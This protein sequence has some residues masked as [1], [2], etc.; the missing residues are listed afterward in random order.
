[1]HK[2]IG[3]GLLVLGLLGA[4]GSAWAEDYDELDERLRAIEDRIGPEEDQ[5]PASSPGGMLGMVNDLQ[6]LQEEV[7]K[8]RGEVERLQYDAEQ[9]RIR[10]RDMFIDI[11]KR[12]SGLENSGQAGQG[13][14]AVI[15][16]PQATPPDITPPTLNSQRPVSSSG[17]P[18]ATTA[19]SQAA[20]RPSTPIA[21]NQ[22]PQ[23]AAQPAP[24]PVQAAD[25][26]AEQQAYLQAFELL[27]K[28]RYDEAIVA[29][30]SFLAGY[31]QGDYADNARYW[32][33][34]TY[35]VKKNYT[36]SLQNFQKLLAEYP[37]SSKLPGA[38]LK[39]GYIQ[40][41]LGNNAEARLALERVR[42]EFAASSVADL[43]SQRLERMDREGR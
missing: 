8:L 37:N 34:E 39:V 16:P 41:E 17:T 23:P 31:P 38:L 28:G 2:F 4:Q 9:N 11:E 18:P 24:P 29:F 7:R 21:S 5:A 13:N 10:Q 20:A 15:P 35:Y 14:T 25:P 6:R 40:Y 42:N 36:V 22:A 32:L 1:M 12:L 26:A 19:P 27:K 30:Q 3:N 43:A 33:A